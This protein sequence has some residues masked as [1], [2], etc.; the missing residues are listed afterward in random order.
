MHFG[1]FPFVESISLYASC[2]T[3]G[4][5]RIAAQVNY[6]LKQGFGFCESGVV[7][8]DFHLHGLGSGVGR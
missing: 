4:L 7:F 5:D 1:S 3:D 6:D 8:H 2:G